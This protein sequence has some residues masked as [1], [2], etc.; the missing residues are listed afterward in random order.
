MSSSTIQSTERWLYFYEYL[1][2]PTCKGVVSPMEIPDVA[3]EF[4]SN[5]ATPPTPPSSSSVDSGSGGSTGNK[6]NIFF[7]MGNSGAPHSGSCGKYGVVGPSPSRYQKKQK[8]PV[9]QPVPVQQQT[10]VAL[11]YSQ[12]R[13]MRRKARYALVATTLPTVCE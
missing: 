10:T 11:S 5:L 2:C 12:R 8:Q 1:W 7:I 9:Q 4:R 13:A 3:M 6:N